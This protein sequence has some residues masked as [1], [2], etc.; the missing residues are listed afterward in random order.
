MRNAWTIAR[1]ELAAYFVSPI[2]YVV[3]AVLV[4]VLALLFNFD[5]LERQ[6]YYAT[7]QYFFSNVT[8]LSFFIIPALTMRLLAEERRVRT[9]E[10]LLT[11]PV[12]ESEVVVGKFLAGL[13]FY[14]GLVLLA[15]VFPLLL[16]AYGNPDPRVLWVNYLGL[17]LFGA[18]LVALGTLASALT[19]NQV[20][21]FIVGFG[22]VVVLW[23]IDTPASLFGSSLAGLLQALSITTHLEGFD[24]G[25]IDT[26]H[27]V[28]FLSVT[29]MALFLATRVL[30]ARRQRG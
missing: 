24:R 22:L 15:S 30:E 8:F 23:V 20:V 13:G 14:L 17:V 21:A 12:R 2:A 6:F 9:M 27:V 19:Q 10:L 11:A 1:R 5:E 29:S 16:F 18:A 25:I 3:A 28:Y 4:I 7:T 26:R